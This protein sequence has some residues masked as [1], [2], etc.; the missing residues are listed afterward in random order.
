MKKRNAGISTVE[1]VIAAVIL[2][3]V[4][5]GVLVAVKMVSKGDDKGGTTADANNIISSLGDH[6][7][8]NVDAADLDVSYFENTLRIVSRDDYQIYYFN[9]NEGQVYYLTKAYAREM[10]D[11]EK[12]TFVGKVTISTSGA[13][14][15]AQ[16]IT[17]FHAT[18]TDLAQANARM[19]LK[20]RVVTDTENVNQ[21]I[22]VNINP[23]LIAFKDGSYAE[24]T[25]TPDSGTEPGTEPDASPSPSPTPSPKPSE[26]EYTGVLATGHGA[27]DINK[28]KKA[29]Q[30]AK[31]K[32]VAKCVD[33]Q[34]A[35]DETSFGIGGLDLDDWNMVGSPWEIKTNT[36]EDAV[37]DEVVK[38][39]DIKQLLAFYES[40][41]AKQIILN[42]YG[43][44]E[45]VEASVVTAEEAE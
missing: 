27:L 38:Y 42:I 13:E 25:P 44:Y 2:A 32:I 9:K 43:G 31:I 21:D 40:G 23:N 33:D 28:L 14:V 37:G 36:I 3:V 18:V 39:F 16:H 5:I 45:L 22:I 26:E 35:D 34:E 1:I 10:T 30:G 15:V 11:E 29:P 24:V 6:V 41:K 12:I 8:A 19:T 17:T 7:R 20:V 4:V